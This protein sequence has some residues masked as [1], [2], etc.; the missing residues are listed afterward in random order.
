MLCS[1]LVAKAQSEPTLLERLT[2]VEKKTDKLKVGIMFRGAREIDTD[3]TEDVFAFRAQD[4][5]IKVDANITKNIYFTY[6]QALNRSTDGSGSFDDLPS[7]L[8]IAGLG[9]RVGKWDIFAGRQFVDYGGYEYDKYA[10]DVYQYSPFGYFTSA[11]HTGL[12]IG[13][14]FSATQTLRFQVV[15]SYNYGFEEQF[16][17]TSSTLERAV[18]PLTYSLYWKGNF[19]SGAYKTI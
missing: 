2:N 9:V 19:F 12:R 17:G 3:A 15:D 11:F 14:D 13:Y 1:S 6:Q 7:S 5:R 4:F 10:M 16:A 8:N 18:A